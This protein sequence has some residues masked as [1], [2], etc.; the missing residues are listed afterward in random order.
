MLL[1]FPLAYKCCK[2]VSTYVLLVCLSDFRNN[3]VSVVCLQPV[4]VS[5]EERERQRLE[6]LQK[7]D[8]VRQAERERKVEEK[9]EKKARKR[10]ERIKKKQQ[11]EHK[12][13]VSV[14]IHCT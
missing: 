3:A 10:E 13:H 7:Q 11:V 9:K 12:V 4:Y 2:C 5:T 8:E 6:D 1:C 14:C